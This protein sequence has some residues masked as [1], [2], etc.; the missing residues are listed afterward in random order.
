ME[1]ERHQTKVTTNSGPGIAKLNVTQG[2]AGSQLLL[3]PKGCDKAVK[4]ACMV[5][6]AKGCK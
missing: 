4:W 6:N 1:I 5:P 3:V 2:T